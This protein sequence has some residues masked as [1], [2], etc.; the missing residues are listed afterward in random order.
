M[1][2][3]KEVGSGK[4]RSVL[5]KYFMVTSDVF[6][7]IPASDLLAWAERILN[8]GPRLSTNM[9]RASFPNSE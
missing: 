5:C 1:Q 6:D 8:D 3:F 2:P 4:A 7:R 9:A